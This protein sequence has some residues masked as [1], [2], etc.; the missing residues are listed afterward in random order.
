MVATV[1]FGDGI[2]RPDLHGLDVALQKF[3]GQT[4]RFLIEIEPVVAGVVNAYGLTRRTAQQFIDRL[5]G[6]FAEQIPERDVDRAEGPHL[7]A[8]PSTVRDGE[9]HVRPQ[10]IDGA[11]ILAQQHGGQTRVHDCCFRLSVGI[12]LS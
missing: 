1:F 10:P 5:S 12:A 4:S 2:E 8:T 6:N 3:P 7:G 9:K 11:G